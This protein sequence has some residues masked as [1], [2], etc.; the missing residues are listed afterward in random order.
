MKVS[1]VMSRRV[2]SVAP[3]AGIRDAIRLMVQHR[4]SGLPVIDGGGNLKGM[5]TEGDF[6]RRAETGTEAKGRWS[7]LDAFFGPA[8][9]AEKYI[10]THGRKVHEVM[11]TDPVTVQESASLEEAVSLMEQQGIKRLPV[12]REGKVAGILTRANL[13]RALL[14]LSRDDSNASTH[15]PR[16]VRARIL[17]EIAKQSWAADTSIDV[18]VRGGVADLWGEITEESQRRALMVLV[19]NTPG[20]RKVYDHLKYESDLITVT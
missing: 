1:D 14:S 13:M 17:N 20:I 12:V 4:I 3:E 9:S 5:L 11:T 7:W 8:E 15:S 2:I 19:E 6:L 10:H 18:I 16:E